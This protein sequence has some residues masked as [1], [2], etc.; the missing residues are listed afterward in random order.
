[1]PWNLHDPNDFN[2]NL[3]LIMSSLLAEK[4]TCPLMPPLGLDEVMQLI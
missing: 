1:M 3:T 2:K 4:L